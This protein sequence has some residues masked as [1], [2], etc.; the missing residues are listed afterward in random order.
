[1]LYKASLKFVGRPMWNTSAATAE[2]LPLLGIY[3]TLHLQGCQVSTSQEHLER[4]ASPPLH[5]QQKK[6]LSPS[7]GLMGGKGGREKS[8]RKYFSRASQ[9]EWEVVFQSERKALSL[10]CGPL[11]L[12]IPWLLRDLHVDQAGLVH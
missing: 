7:N 8:L 9:Y 6:A 12:L 10:G 4:M 2:V 11:V 3:K 1:M 5:Q